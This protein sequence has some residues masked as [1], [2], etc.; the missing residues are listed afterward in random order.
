MSRCEMRPAPDLIA[1]VGLEAVQRIF[2]FLG[3]DRDGL[4]APARWRRERRGWRFRSG[5]RPVSWLSARQALRN[6]EEVG[7]GMISGKMLQCKQ[8]RQRVQSIKSR[9]Q[10]A[11]TKTRPRLPGSGCKERGA[12]KR[13]SHRHVGDLAVGALLPDVHD[14]GLVELVAD[15]VV[16]DVAD[17]GRDLLAGVEAL[18]RPWPSPPRRPSRCRTSAPAWRHRRRACRPPG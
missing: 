5:W 7:S 17:D 1:L 13:R 6:L 12:P 15:L 10:R 8:K 3:P 18:R 14:I 9:A 16:L 11:T 4:R 2:V